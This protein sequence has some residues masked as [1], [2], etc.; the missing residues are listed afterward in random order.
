MIAN[1]ATLRNG[2]IEQF[3]WNEDTQPIYKSRRTGYRICELKGQFV[4]LKG[5][6]HLT[7]VGEYTGHKDTI[8]HLGTKATLH[9]AFDLILIHSRD[10]DSEFRQSVRK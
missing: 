2:S 3:I 10:T 7:T 6:N 9:E 5:W 8:L 1:T 4:V